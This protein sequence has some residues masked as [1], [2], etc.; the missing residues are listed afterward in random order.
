VSKLKEKKMKTKRELVQELRNAAN[1]L[2]LIPEDFQLEAEHAMLIND[3]LSLSFYSKEKFVAAVKTLGNVT[4]TYTDGEYA[5]LIVESDTVPKIR[6][7]ISRDKV[8]TKKVVYDCEALF[9]AEEV[10]SL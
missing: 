7:R 4:K 10:E 2:D 9:S 5:E 1:A 8:C 3:V 6:L